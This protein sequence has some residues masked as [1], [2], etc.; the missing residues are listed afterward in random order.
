MT[1]DSSILVERIERTILTVRGNRVMID[2]DLAEMFGVTTKALNQAVKRN[3]ERFPSQFMFRLSESEKAEVVTNCD[4]LKTLKFSPTNPLAFT[5]HGVLMAATVLNSPRAVQMS[6][7]IV[8][9]FVRLRELLGSNVE[10]ARKLAELERRHDAQF[11]VVF[12]AIRQLMASPADP[13][14][15]RIGFE[16]EEQRRHAKAIRA[17]ARTTGK[18]V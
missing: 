10:L 4:H 14:K 15:P 1:H 5:E 12:D 16:T 2:A 8:R 17:G 18:K 3:T 7:A 9:A 13:P 11:K 6:L